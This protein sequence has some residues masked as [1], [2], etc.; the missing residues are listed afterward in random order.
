MLYLKFIPGK[1]LI[2]FVTYIIERKEEMRDQCLERGR[3]KQGKGNDSCHI[4][5]QYFLPCFLCKH[6]SI[7]FQNKNGY[8]NI[9]IRLLIRET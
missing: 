8:F 6:P 3:K 4:S 2:I 1:Y 7:L 9:K 5:D